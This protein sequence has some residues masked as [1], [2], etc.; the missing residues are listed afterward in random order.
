MGPTSTASGSI[1][2]TE[3]ASIPSGTASDIA[4]TDFP[5]HATWTRHSV[6]TNLSCARNSRSNATTGAP[7]I[8]A[9]ITATASGAFSTTT[10]ALTA[11]DNRPHP[12]RFGRP[13]TTNSFSS[14]AQIAVGGGKVELY[15]LDALAK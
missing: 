7:A 4:W 10:G 15:R 2:R 6:G 5:H 11:H 14:K 1:R 8:A 3:C 9:A 13:M 12:V